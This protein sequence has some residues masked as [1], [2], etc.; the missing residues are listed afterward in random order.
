MA[1][2]IYPL[3]IQ[4]VID[5]RSKRSKIH[6]FF[7][8]LVDVGNIKENENVIILL[9]R[10]EELIYVVESCFCEGITYIPVDCSFPRNRISYIIDDVKSKLI[11]TNRSNK[12][13]YGDNA[14]YVEDIISS[15]ME[16]RYEYRVNEIPENRL[17]Y[18]IYS[19]NF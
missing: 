8:T 13:E 3:S 17:A 1:E 15:D 11:I 10:T 6:R 14:I 2:V 7:R 5:N 9:E 12:M 16:S 19:V 4:E 18:I